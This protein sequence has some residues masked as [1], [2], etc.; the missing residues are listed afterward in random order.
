VSPE[1]ADRIAAMKFPGVHQE[2]EYRRFYP[3]GDMTAHIVGFTGVDDKGL[4]GVELAFQQ[5]AGASGQSYRDSRPA[6]Q[7]RRGRRRDQAAAGWQGCSPGARLQDPVPGLQ[8]A[9]EAVEKHK[10]RPA[11]PS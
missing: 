4:E 3:T 2:K 5:P 7:H 8:P 9:Q 11:A 6:R 10:P 1:T